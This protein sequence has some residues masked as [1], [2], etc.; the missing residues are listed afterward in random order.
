[1]HQQPEENNRY[2]KHRSLRRNPKPA[3]LSEKKKRTRKIRKGVQSPRDGFRQ[4][5]KQRERAERDN[6]RWQP[7]PGDETGIDSSGQRAN[8]YRAR[9]SRRNG[10]VSVAPKFSK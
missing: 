8:D 3:F 9:S 10:E 7:K 1:M 5:T 6:E 4:T 2:D